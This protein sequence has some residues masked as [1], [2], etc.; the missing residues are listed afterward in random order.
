MREWGRGSDL[1][2]LVLP[3]LVSG[4][5]RDRDPLIC[6]DTHVTFGQAAL[7]VDGARLDGRSFVKDCEA[8]VEYSC[9]IL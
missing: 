3:V 7:R 8:V 6:P 1:R 4:T 9:F 5:Y 2:A